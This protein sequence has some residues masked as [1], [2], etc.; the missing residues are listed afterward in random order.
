MGAV[1]MSIAVTGTCDT[2][3]VTVLRSG[4]HGGRDLCLGVLMIDLSCV[5]LMVVRRMVRLRLMMLEPRGVRLVLLL[6][7][8]DMLLLRREH[9][10]RGAVGPRIK[11]EQVI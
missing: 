10:E 4:V 5:L 1:V 9:D 3:V 2:I 11:H 7:G 8:K 6:M